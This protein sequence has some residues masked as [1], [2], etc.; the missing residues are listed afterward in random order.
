MITE[1]FNNTI[2]LVEIKHT[3]KDGVPVIIKETKTIE[4]K[5]DLKRLLNKNI[6]ECFENNLPQK[7]IGI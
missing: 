3:E 7:R 2:T 6:K 5:V 4:C 1:P